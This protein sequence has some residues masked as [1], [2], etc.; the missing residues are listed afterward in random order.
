MFEVLLSLV[1]LVSMSGQHPKFLKSV[2]FMLIVGALIFAALNTLPF[3]Q[4]ASEAFALRIE[5]ASNIEGGLEGTLIDRF[6]GGLYSSVSNPEASFYGHGLGM[7][8]NAGA[9]LM[10]GERAFLISEGEWGRLIGEMG[11]ILGMLAIMVRLGLVLE[12]LK[13][14]WSNIGEGNVLPWMLLSFGTLAILQGQWAQPTALGFSALVGG[15]VIS[16]LNK[17]KLPE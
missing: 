8:T 4:T 3:F 5:N 14:A 9:Q 11:F 16:A 6:L 2:A 7:G 15:L 1:F 17:E 13:K 10:T 12:L